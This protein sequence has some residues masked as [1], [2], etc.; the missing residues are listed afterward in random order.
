MLAFSDDG[1]TR[2]KYDPEQ[3]YMRQGLILL[4]ALLGGPPGMTRMLKA[5]PSVSSRSRRI[6]FDLK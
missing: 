1:L 4:K 3:Y 2:M 5:M 6:G